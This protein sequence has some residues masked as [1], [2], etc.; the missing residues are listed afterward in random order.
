MPSIPEA[1]YPLIPSD[2]RPAVVFD[3]VQDAAITGLNV[4]GVKDAESALRF[5]DVKDVLITAPRLL[6]PASVFLQVEGAD[7][8]NI[9]LDGGDLSKSGKP[10]A[11]KNGANA[12]S[13]KLRV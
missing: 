6:A 10:V 9:T 12:K 13:V 7:T 3:H 1:S 11:F 4:Q 5:I 2:L 8:E